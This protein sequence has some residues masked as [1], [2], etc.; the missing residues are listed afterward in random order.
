MH[1]ALLFRYTGTLVKNTQSHDITPAFNPLAHQNFT[2]MSDITRSEGLSYQITKF[3]KC[4]E[5]LTSGM[6][7]TLEYNDHGIHH[8][9]A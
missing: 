8:T 5:I 6:D 1:T 9:C 4:L 7:I 3:D 2:T